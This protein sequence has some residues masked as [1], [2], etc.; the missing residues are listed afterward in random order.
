MKLRE[1]KD[2]LSENAHFEIEYNQNL[3]DKISSMES[4]YEIPQPR[5]HLARKLIFSISSVIILVFTFV[6]VLISNQVTSIITLDINPSVSLEVNRFGKVI[7]IIPNNEDGE[8]LVSQT[9][10]NGMNYLRVIDC[11]VA[12]SVSLGFSNQS[13]SYLLFGV[14]SSDYE[15][16]ILLSS[17]I[18][19]YLQTD[20]MNMLFVSKHSSDN[21]KYYAGLASSVSSSNIPEG[22]SST[23]STTA[24]YDPTGALDDEFDFIIVNSTFRTYQLSNLTPTQYTSLANELHITEAKLQIVL[25]VFFYYSN[26]QQDLGLESVAGL[27]LPELFTLYQNIPQ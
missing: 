25:S 17:S 19:S 16:E 13:S 20:S 10:F 18:S 15:D 21:T 26:I 14:A 24:F 22:N 3:V 4:V 1:F 11:L 7:D 2:I 5:I 23:L 6:G 9:D 12:E 8:F 27:D